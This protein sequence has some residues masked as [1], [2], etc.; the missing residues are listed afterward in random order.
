MVAALQRTEVNYTRKRTTD[1]VVGIAT[2]CRLDG[3]GIESIFCA[4]QNSFEAHPDF[5]GMVTVPFLELKR[6][7]NFS[8]HPLPSSTR[9]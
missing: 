5:S 9:F 1:V 2:H 3:P 4:I 6:P 8:Y 7:E